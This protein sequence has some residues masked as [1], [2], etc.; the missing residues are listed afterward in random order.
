M[1]TT[2][3]DVVFDPHIA[4]E[5]LT[6]EMDRQGVVFIGVVCTHDGEISCDGSGPVT[7]QSNLLDLGKDLLDCVMECGSALPKESDD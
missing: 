2:V 7:F 4:L 1:K 5:K 6:D 3:S